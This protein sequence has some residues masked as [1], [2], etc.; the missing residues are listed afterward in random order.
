M[1][2]G[3]VFLDRKLWMKR[4]ERSVEVSAWHS[5]P[6]CEWSWGIF[7]GER[8]GTNQDRAGSSSG[9]LESFK[10]SCV[11]TPVAMKHVL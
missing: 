4:E 1:S 9:G 7:S 8:G 6:L 11:L 10:G 5:D 2:S 3:S